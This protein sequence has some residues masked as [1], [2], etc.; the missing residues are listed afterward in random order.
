MPMQPN[1]AAPSAFQ[2]GPGPAFP[3]AA[4]PLDYSYTFQETLLEATGVCV[5]YDKPVLRDMNFRIRNIVRPGHNQ[6]Q[7]NALLAPSG[8]GKSTFFRVLAGLRRPDAG[9]VMIGDPGDLVNPP[10][11]VRTGGVGVVAQDFPLFAHLTVL[12][13]L[14]L[15]AKVKIKDHK[16]RVDTCVSYL[17]SFGLAERRNVYPHQLSGGQRQRVSIIQQVVSCGHMLLMDE[18]FSGLDVLRKESVQGLISQIAAAHEH[19][20][21]VMTT[22]DIAAAL[23]IA[24]TVDIMGIERD[25]EGNRIPGAKI[26]RSYNLMDMGITWRENNHELP[27]FNE[28]AREIKA[29]FH[30]I[31]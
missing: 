4:S 21:I 14:L 18:P 28:L 1:P 15:A 23:A 8:M 7:V 25:T 9:S 11:P 10:H 30:E 3:A 13:N 16:E 6:G 20:S 29:L 12:D 26:V 5:A 27:Q 24:D 31:A 17:E 19:N 22:H 2:Y